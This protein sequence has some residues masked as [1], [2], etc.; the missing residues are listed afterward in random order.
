MAG[1]NSAATIMSRVALGQVYGHLPKDDL[2]GLR[3][4]APHLNLGT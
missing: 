2:P 1:L 4:A 3:V